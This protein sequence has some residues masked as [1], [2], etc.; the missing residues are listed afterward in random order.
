[1]KAL[2]LRGRGEFE[3]GLGPVEA[4]D[5]LD[6]IEGSLRYQ[7]CNDRSGICYP[8]KRVSIEVALP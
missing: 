2:V 5:G 4:L 6:E 7:I 8:P 3:F 1:M